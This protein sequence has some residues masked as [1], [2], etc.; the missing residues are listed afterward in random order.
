MRI[1]KFSVHN[2]RSITSTQEI[3]LS[4]F[5]TLIGPN[6]EGKSNLLRAL[7]IA[8]EM[9]RS[10]GRFAVRRS[11]GIGRATDELRYSWSRDFPAALQNDPDSA[12]TKFTLTFSLSRREC[13]AL[14][15][16]VKKNIKQNLSTTI[17]VQ[18][19]R[20]SMQFFT[21]ENE[22]DP[23]GSIGQYYFQ[24]ISQFIH[25]N[26]GLVYIPAVRTADNS[27]TIIKDL[28]SRELS[29]LIYDREYLRA[30]KTVRK[31]QE[32]I[33]KKLSDTISTT[34]RLFMPNVRNVSIN[35]PDKDRATFSL[36]ESL[37]IS[38]NDG[39]N[40]PLRLKGDGFQSLAAIAIIKHATE[41]SSIGKSLVIA[42]E[43]PES[44]LHQKSIHYLRPV[45]RELSKTNQVLIH[46]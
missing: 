46:H 21:F 37:Q 7:A 13:K 17:S 39:T 24:V 34:L 41:K 45:L 11:F 25:K 10:G 42:V 33:L 40:T 19:H 27:E 1:S 6:N 30:I 36:S 43:E 5:T 12:A 16:I 23:K 3:T 38:V 35:L 20:P 44:H 9:M 8:F 28:L 14:S 2:F 26:L 4:A 15:N 18:R 29:V 22:G 32:P 31:I